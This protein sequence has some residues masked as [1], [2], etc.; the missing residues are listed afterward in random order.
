MIAAARLLVAA[1]VAAAGLVV[2][3][4]S[5]GSREAWAHR[6]GADGPLAGV[7]YDVAAAKPIDERD[8]VA[9]LGDHE[10]VL[11]GDAAGNVDHARL[12]ARLVQGFAGEGRR[13]AAVALGPLPSDAQPE[14]TAYTAEHP[15]DA[16][17]LAGVVQEAAP[18][19]PQLAR[20]TPVVEATVAAGA[21]L[22]APD[23]PAQSLRG[24]LAR[25]LGA[26]QPAFVRRTGLTGA[27]P[28][29]LAAQLREELAVVSCDRADS[30][31]LD[32]LVR[33]RRARDASMADRLAA[34]TGR[35]QSLLVAEATHVRKDRGVPWYLARLRPD[36]RVAT[37]ALVELPPDGGGKAKAPELLAGLPYDYVWFTPRS[38]P[39]G[40]DPCRPGV[41]AGPDGDGRVTGRPA[42][43]AAVGAIR[44]AAN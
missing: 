25:G 30:R 17:G 9:R 27:L 31:T 43:P 16:A 6:D 1:L 2:G 33:A 23:L 34:I 28:P 21:Q 19:R 7:I 40:F 37:V 15:K 35:G 5:G 39:A 44:A 32:S 36:A 42:P 4:C 3:G 13:L 29:A 12:A 41:Q 26:L 38:R 10:I 11:V 22:V 14:V 8:L 24:V 20:L 18:D